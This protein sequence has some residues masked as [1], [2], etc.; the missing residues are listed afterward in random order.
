MRGERDG[1]RFLGGRLF[2]KSGG[3]KRIALL[4]ATAL[5]SSGLPL[6]AAIAAATASLAAAVTP[7]ATEPAGGPITIDGPVVNGNIETSGSRDVYTF[8]VPNPG[9]RVFLH[10]TAGACDCR[11]WVLRDSQLRVYPEPLSGYQ[12][13]HDMGPVYLPGGA[14]TLTVGANPLMTEDAPG[15]YSFQLFGLPDTP[16][17][18]INLGDTVSGNIA[19]PGAWVQYTFAMPTG[20]GR[21]YFQMLSGATDVRILTLRDGSGRVLS[22][23]GL[24]SFGPTFLPAGNYS[25]TVQG[26][27]PAYASAVGTYSFKLWS[28]VDNSATIPT[29]ALILNGYIDRLVNNQWVLSAENGVGNLETPGSEDTYTFTVP[30]ATSQRVSVQ[31]VAGSSTTPT[32]MLRDSLG[33]VLAESNMTDLPPVTLYQGT[34][35]LT[36]GSTKTYPVDSMGTYALHVATVATQPTVA[37]TLPYSITGTSTSAA[38]NIETSGS[39]DTYTFS[40]T[41]HTRISIGSTSNCA[42][43]LQQFTLTSP[44]LHLIVPQTRLCV[45]AVLTLPDTGT[46]TLVVGGSTGLYNMRVGAPAANV[47]DS[48]TITTFQRFTFSRL[49]PVTIA[50]NSIT[51]TINGKPSTTAATGAGVLEAGL[52]RD[53]FT[54]SA[55]AGER[56]YIQQLG[57]SSSTARIQVFGPDGFLVGSNPMVVD[58]GSVTTNQAGV[59]SIVVDDMTNAATTY[60]FKLWRMSDSYT[61]LPLGATVQDGKITTATGSVLPASGAANLE[62]LGAQDVYSFT[63]PSPGSRVYLRVASGGVAPR[64]MTLRDSAGRT[65]Y[66]SYL[67]DASPWNPLTGQNALSYLP[68][69]TYTLTVG[70][71]PDSVPAPTGAYSLSISTVNEPANV[72]LPMGSTIT[73]GHITTGTS[74]TPTSGVGNIETFGTRDT[75]TFTANA[76]DQMY[77]KQLS[78]TTLPPQRFEWEVRG[79]DGVELDKALSDAVGDFKVTF[80]KSG[81]QMLTVWGDIA[82][83]GTY[84]LETWADAPITPVPITIGP[85]VAGN[86][87][88]PGA[89]DMYTFA[90]TAGT[91]VRLDWA[92]TSTDT[93]LGGGDSWWEVRG[94]D[95]IMLAGGRPAMGHPWWGPHPGYLMLPRTGTYT[96]N[97]WGQYWSSGTYHFRL[98]ARPPAEHFNYTIGATVSRNVP[99]LGAGVIEQ[100]GSQDV[101]GFNAVAGQQLVLHD[102][103]VN[104]GTGLYDPYYTLRG[105]DGVVKFTFTPQISGAGGLNIVHDYPFTLARSGQYTLE[106]T[107]Q[108]GVGAGSYSFQLQDKGITQVD[109]VPAP[110]TFTLSE[111][112]S[113]TEGVIHK[114]DGSGDVPAPGAGQL[115]VNGE[116]VYLINVTSGDALNFDVTTNCNTGLWPQYVTAPPEWTLRD[117]DG[118]LI[119]DQTFAPNCDFGPI[120]LPKTGAYTLTVKLPTPQKPQSYGFAVEK[121]LSMQEAPKT[122]PIPSPTL[123]R[124]D[125]GTAPAGNTATLN[126]YGTNLPQPTAVH[127]KP[128]GPT[129]TGLPLTLQSANAVPTNIESIAATVDVDVST[130]AQGTYVVS[131]DFAN[132]TTMQLA[133]NFT[134]NAPAPPQ[135]NITVDSSALFAGQSNEVFV[136]VQN[137]GKSDYYDL[138]LQVDVPP[139]VTASEPAAPG[140]KDAFVASYAAQGASQA[141]LDQVRA[142][143]LDADTAP[144]IAPNGHSHF[145]SYILEVGSGQSVS[146][147]IVITSGAAGSA[148]DIDVSTEQSDPVELKDPTDP[149]TILEE[150]LWMWRVYKTVITTAGQKAGL[151]QQQIDETINVIWVL[152]W[153]WTFYTLRETW[154]RP[155]TLPEIAREIRLMMTLLISLGKVAGQVASEFGAIVYAI[156]TY[157]EALLGT[158]IL[159]FLV[160]F[161]LAVVLT[162][163]FTIYVVET[164]PPP[165]GPCCTG[166]P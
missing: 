116:D 73:N 128:V 39:V 41:A 61:T 66:D 70:T 63:I 87:E 29:N 101:Y 74:D 114:G 55:A 18:P 91:E 122:A 154:S 16:P 144:V 21:V 32:L 102:M 130:A 153:S 13:L 113:V 84:S 14:Y 28:V 149:H 82:S 86:L 43:S 93:L 26:I 4:V 152:G 90:G 27:Y 160:L 20:G 105:P 158:E 118:A 107:N 146:F 164:T 127:I 47:A 69:G 165:P 56:Y 161:T 60:S 76:G 77:L 137:T 112:D 54:F 135:V 42:Q 143:N 40:G 30:I 65:M 62:T 23:G 120:V 139:G 117:P 59:Y 46:Y 37:M 126:I 3:K 5:I 151:S 157:F 48:V 2:V 138:A 38:G 162:L 19:K 35:T 51:T 9:E 142:S 33:R 85:T 50:T 57:A 140:I 109:P 147:P 67:Y 10:L 31:V 24:Q 132:D 108:G 103:F 79:P 129:T 150:E 98:W 119:M 106:V 22:E 110:Q 1:L 156:T 15:Q 8:T 83:T 123:T 44:S 71:E 159:L 148:G 94:V 121:L 72:P 141:F 80:L 17:I 6:G 134:V 92:D 75:Y 7:P 111:G 88:N 155:I 125:P 81:V 166:D 136:T 145:I 25:I 131:V 52:T 68:A 99:A 95:G 58:V 64:W 104:D 12:P 89:R 78:P 34:Y 45:G 36:V 49:F 96:I 53:Q 100:D 115:E 133:Q 163:T 97:V 124:I 11:M